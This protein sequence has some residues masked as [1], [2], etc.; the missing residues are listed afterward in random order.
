MKKIFIFLKN[1]ANLQEIINIVYKT[2]KTVK[3]YEKMV[4]NISFLLTFPQS[5]DNIILVKNG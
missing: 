4:S 2:H 3:M 1:N 5:N